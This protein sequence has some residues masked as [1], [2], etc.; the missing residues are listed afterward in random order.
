MSFG[1]ANAARGS[2][3]YF[4]NA[5]PKVLQLRLNREPLKFYAAAGGVMQPIEFE[6]D[7]DRDAIMPPSITPSARMYSVTA[8]RHT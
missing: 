5:C 2:R 8:N 6:C 3:K 7:N 1:G 4:L